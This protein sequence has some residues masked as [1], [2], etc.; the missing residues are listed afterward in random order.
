MINEF[1]FKQEQ[2]F[3]LLDEKKLDALI[4]NRV[5]S[6]A[7][8]TCG[9]SSYVGVSATEGVATLVITPSHRYLLTNNIEAQRLEKEEQLADQGW[10][11]LVSPWYES[12]HT[13]ARLTD[14]LKVGVDEPL[15]AGMDLSTEIARLRVNLTQPEGD[16]FRK[17]GGECAQAMDQAMRS[18]RPGQTE[19]QIAARLALETETRGVQPVCLLVATDERIFSYRHP[20]PK[21]K[22]MERYAMVVLC[23]RKWGL[24]CSITRLVHFGPLSQEVR[25]KAESVAQ[26]DAVMIAD[27]RPGRSLGEV[28][29]S[30]QDA[31]SRAGFPD[32]WQMHHQGG[33]AG[34]E[35]REFVAVPGMKESVAAGQVFAWNPSIRGTKSEDTIL[36]SDSGNEILTVIPGWPVVTVQLKEQTILRPA[37]LEV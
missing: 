27:T 37:I 35:A 4:L 18:I 21:D 5:S 22:T 16:R 25:H 1:I 6:F 34:Y 26:V 11:F 33:S 17:L 32:E 2:L 10:E 31:Y 3:K 29:T 19:R 13:L 15:P 8:A 24:V 9:G 20:L 36:V 23:G 28:F 12:N 14:G 30:A 7:W